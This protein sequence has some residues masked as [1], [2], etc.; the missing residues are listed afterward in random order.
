MGRWTEPSP[1]DFDRWE[2]LIAEGD[3]PSRAAKALGFGGS[4]SF[5]RADAQRHAETLA[6]WREA[7]QQ[8]DVEYV[9]DKLRDNVEAAMSEGERNAAN[10]GLELIGKQAGMFD[11]RIEIDHGGPVEVHVDHDFPGIV[12]TLERIGLVRAGPAA[13]DAE[14]VEVLPA[15]TDDAP[16]GGADSAQPAAA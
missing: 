2:Q 1:S 3:D 8:D 15:R 12:E 10:R 7:R 9:R 11:D 16:G 14:A 5:K 4:S 6:W 13:V